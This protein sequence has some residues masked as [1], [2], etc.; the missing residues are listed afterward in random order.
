[1][2]VP[3]LAFLAL[4]AAGG[5][6]TTTPSA[7]SEPGMVSA[8]DP[9]AAAAGAEMLRAGGSAADAALATL[10]A[11]TVV[12]PQSSGI[13]GGGF[14]VYEDGDGAPDTYDGR[15]TAPMAAT[16]TWFFRDGKP[17]GIREAIPG[18]KSVGVPGNLRLM[19]LAHR[20]QGRLPWGRLFEPA[21]R[22]AREGFAI[23]PRLHRALGRSRETGALSDP[24]RALFYAANGNPHPVGTIVRNEALAAFLDQLAA[25]GADSFYVGP[26]AQTI[27]ATVN[28]APRNPSQM[29]AGDLAAYDAKPRPPVCGTYRRHRICGMGPPSSG[30]TTV[31]AIVKQLERF[32]LRALGPTSPTSWHLIAESM[33]LAFADRD[34]FL[35]DSD[36]QPVPVAGLVDAGYLAQRSALIAPDRTLADVSYGV[37]PGANVLVCAR[38]PSFENGT[39]HFV[40][41]DRWGEVAS[42]TSTIESVFGSGLMVNGY[43]LNNELT[44]FSLSPTNH[45]CPVANR[46][47]PGKRPRSSMSPTIVYGPD[48]K[49]RLAVGAAGGATIIAQVAKAII[50]VIDWNLSAQQAIALPVLFAPG[51][52]VFVERGSAHEAMIPALRSLGHSKVEAREPG[53][54][55]NAIERVNGR[56]IGAA[57]PRSEGAAVGE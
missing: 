20:D 4:L 16:G 1:M 53:F 55:A 10:V 57:D 18:G 48:G 38:S 45:D 51:D 54:K 26:N 2:R 25:R 41:V 40:A 3:V 6:A 19:A 23:T 7:T 49:V 8:A 35:A 56:W 24:A 13:G 5:C 43:Y 46:V 11:L 14:L 44:D 32:D 28:G 30:A 27:V 9:R 39:S 37:P 21:I 12:E 22:L 50:G 31:F 33:R 34:F 42:L 47:E 29:T 17:M 15:E 52:T 36:F